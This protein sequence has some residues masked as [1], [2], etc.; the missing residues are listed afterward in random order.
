MGLGFLNDSRIEPCQIQQPIASRPENSKSKE[1]YL[2]NLVLPLGTT[3]FEQREISLFVELLLSNKPIPKMNSM[4]QK[5]YLVAK[6]IVMQILQDSNS[7]GV[8]K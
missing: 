1:Y 6:E 4:S 7:Q 3:A 8:S 5:S 2:E